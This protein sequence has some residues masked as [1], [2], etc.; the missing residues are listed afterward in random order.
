MDSSSTPPLIAKIDS[1]SPQPTPSSSIPSPLPMKTKRH[2][3]SSP[4]S[5]APRASPHLL[6]H[7]TSA[8]SHGAN[9]LPKSPSSS[10]WICK[11]TR[12][13]RSHQLISKAINSSPLLSMDLKPRNPNTW[14]LWVAALNTRWFIGTS[15]KWSSQFIPWTR[16]R[17]LTSKAVSVLI[18]STRYSST[19][20]MTPSSSWG[21]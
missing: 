12:R 5:L 8:T 9:K 4:P 11:R 21:K 18:D 10:W 14:L 7:T 17:R 2:S 3:P 15:R 16:L 13:S 20:K 19:E 1:F 6:S